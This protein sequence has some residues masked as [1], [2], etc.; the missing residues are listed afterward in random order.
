MI[1]SVCVKENCYECVLLTDVRDDIMHKAL[2]KGNKN[3]QSSNRLAP[4]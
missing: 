1:F 2:D 3:A 4:V